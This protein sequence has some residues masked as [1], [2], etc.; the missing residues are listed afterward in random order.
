MTS[1]PGFCVN[2]ACTF[3]TKTG[4]IFVRIGYFKI[5]CTNTLIRRYRCKNC[6]K[7]FSSRT[8]KPDYCHKKPHL[9]DIFRKLLCEGVTLRGASRAL[10]MTYRN[11]YLKFLWLGRQ[12][13]IEKQALSCNANIIYFD[14]METIEHT[15]CKPLS[16]ALMVSEEYKILEARVA[17]MPAK[18]KLSK[19]SNRKYGKREDD[20]EGALKTAFTSLC[21]KLENTPKLIKSDAKPSYRKHVNKHFPSVEYQIHCRVNKEHQQSRLHEK[22][23]KKM[24][25]PMFALNQRCAK[26]RA[27]IKRLARRSWVTTKKPENLQL[28]LDIYIVAQF[29]A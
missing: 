12:A 7:S 16:I 2:K 21:S 28:H 26:L 5:K 23:Y 1:L 27:D 24:F 25:D 17:K 13:Q 9:N 19:F 6:L 8:L 22:K 15:K 3:H 29:V 4:G 20:R 10:K 11:T 14:E 18:G